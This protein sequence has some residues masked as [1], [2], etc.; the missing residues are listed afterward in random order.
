M[1]KYLIL[2]TDG[3]CFSVKVEH[4]HEAILEVWKKYDVPYEDFINEVDMV[5]WKENKKWFLKNYKTN[6]TEINNESKLKRFLNIKEVNQQEEY[7]EF[8]GE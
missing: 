5:E 6:S 3:T 2:M 1:P 4:R 7:Q 8:Y